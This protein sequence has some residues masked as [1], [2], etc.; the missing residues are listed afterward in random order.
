[1]VPA[2]ARFLCLTTIVLVICFV[3]KTRQGEWGGGGMLD[4]DDR[5]HRLPF[6]TAG[7]NAFAVP[8]AL[9]L[10]WVFK[11]VWAVVG[12][13]LFKTPVHELGHSILAWLRGCW[14][15]PFP[16]AFSFYDPEPSMLVTAIVGLGIGYGLWQAWAERATS[17]L[18]LFSALAAGW[19][20]CA[21]VLTKAQWE[22]LFIYAG[23][24]GEIVLST[25]VILAF[26]HRLPGLRWDFLRYPLM[27]AAA[28]TLA[29]AVSYWAS[30]QPDPETM[31]LWGDKLSQSRDH[32][33]DFVRLVQDWHWTPR[34]LADRSLLLGKVCLGMVLA[35]YARFLWVAF[36][37]KPDDS[38]A[39]A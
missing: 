23:C 39:A 18:A 6:D 25:L 15:F 19:V 35:Y 5:S 36:S 3:V 38:G 2:M 37:R 33:N 22:P 29:G 13:F 32:E 14:S 7:V 34:Q 31:I 8:L 24:A 20:C 11:G 21:F 28:F 17:A 30:V 9:L 26:Y 4:L 27:A 1:M 10:G 12:F 16:W